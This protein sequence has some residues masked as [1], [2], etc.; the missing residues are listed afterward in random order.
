MRRRASSWSSRSINAMSWWSSAQSMPQN[1]SMIFIP[2]VCVLLMPA[3]SRAGHAR[4][5]ME[6]LKGTAIRLAVRDPSRPQGPRPGWSS[7]APVSVR[8]PSCG[9]QRPR[10]P[11]R[12][13][14]PACGRRPACR[15]IT[16]TAAGP[17]PGSIMRIKA[18]VY[19]A[20]H[21]APAA[22]TI[23]RP[24]RSALEHPRAMSVSGMDPAGMPA[25][26]F[27]G[28]EPWIAMAVTC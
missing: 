2:Q 8:G 25:A 26:W 13:A 12:P 20:D 16:G 14:H 22:I 1:T 5:L 6:G 27:E 3:L 4:S 18:L 28:S 15:A 11:Y 17:G 24:C 19:G 10:P 21:P 23:T 9:W 7:E